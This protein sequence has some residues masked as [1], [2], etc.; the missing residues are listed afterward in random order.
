MF[1]IILHI[2]L[3]LNCPHSYSMYNNNVHGSDGAG[4]GSILSWGDP[5]TPSELHMTP[6]WRGRRWKCSRPPSCS[7]SVRAAGDPSPG[8]EALHTVRD[9]W[10]SRWSAR[11]GAPR[12][13]G[14]QPERRWSEDKRCRLSSACFPLSLKCFAFLTKLYNSHSFVQVLKRN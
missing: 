11:G 9:R 3:F 5:G 4:V 2:D 13:Q 8:T 10:R 14:L 12:R 7:F 1:Y 6:G